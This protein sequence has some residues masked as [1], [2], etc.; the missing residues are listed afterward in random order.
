MHAK[1]ISG[2]KP[3]T[4]TFHCHLVMSGRHVCAPQRC[5]NLALSKLRCNR[6][7]CADPPRCGERPEQARET[8]C[9]PP[10]AQQSQM[11]APAV[12]EPRRLPRQ[13]LAAAA[14]ASPQP[15]Q[16]QYH[17]Q[18][19]SA[20]IALPGFA[21]TPHTHAH[22]CTSGVA[23]APCHTCRMNPAF[24]VIRRLGTIAVHKAYVCAKRQT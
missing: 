24:L 14:V 23:D 20:C 2:C 1:Y 5:R 13:T 16:R 6:P 19:A 21:S 12:P 9:R 3:A 17:S 7:A 10:A 15:V 11:G 18:P 8:R 22:A 4:Y